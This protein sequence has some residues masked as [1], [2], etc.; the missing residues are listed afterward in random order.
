M[1]PSLLTESPS[2]LGSEPSAEDPRCDFLQLPIRIKNSIASYISLFFQKKT[3]THA[4]RK[5]TYVHDAKLSTI[6]QAYVVCQ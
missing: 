4:K 6:Y 3:V 5:K 2:S 1:M